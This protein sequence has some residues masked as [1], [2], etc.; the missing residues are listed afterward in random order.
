MFTEIQKAA[1]R[2][3]GR[4]D[5]QP[6]RAVK[7]KC[8]VGSHQRGTPPTASPSKTRNQNRNVR[9]TAQKIRWQIVF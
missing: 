7:S 4:G 9:T 2:A 5:R 1:M 8:L 6:G 3:L